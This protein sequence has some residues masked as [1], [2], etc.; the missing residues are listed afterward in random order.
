VLALLR[1]ICVSDGIAAV[2][3]L[4]QVQLARRFADRIVGL[5][6]GAV[7]FDG[8]PDALTNDHLARIY[9]QPVQE[10][11]PH[12]VES[13]SRSHDLSLALATE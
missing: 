6:D 12:A 11:V 2:V 7:V 5:L 3:S 8:R 4:H 13:G 10:A 1:D 9:R